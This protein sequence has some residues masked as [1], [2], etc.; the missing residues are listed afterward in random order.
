MENFNNN[1]NLNFELEYHVKTIKK[2]D[3]HF[4]SWLFSG[5]QLKKKS[6]SILSTLNI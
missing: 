1:K 5:G 2:S 4:P 3:V 6:K